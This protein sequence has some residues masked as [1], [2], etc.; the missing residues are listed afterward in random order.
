LNTLLN[1]LLSRDL[2]GVPLSPAHAETLL[3]ARG[4]DLAA[5]I[6]VAHAMRLERCGRTVR[7]CGILN[8]R[9]GGCTEDCA[10][11]AQARDSEAAVEAYALLEADPIVA[12]ARRGRAAG[13]CRFSIVTSGR[14]MTRGRDLDR[15]C[16]AIR[17]IRDEVGVAVCASLGVLDRAA[18]ER[19][20]EAGL[21]RYHHNLEAPPSLYGEICTTHPI[22]E[23]IT[24]ARDAR[25]VGLELCCGGILGLGESPSQRIELL[26]AIAEL[27][28]DAVPINF[29]EPIPGTGLA[30][31]PTLSPQEALAAVAVASLLVPEAELILCGG[32]EV[33]LRSLQPLA[34]L[35]GANGLMIGDYLTTPG[36]PPERDIEMIRDLGLEALELER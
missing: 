2:A 28:P 35:A 12:A 10:F 5:L 6:A 26:L 25:A 27:E 18:L 1:S 17:R 13:A 11:C 14:G 32:R 4:P 15:V 16:E 23:R 8:A 21:T 22:E 29:L 9:S 33:T 30:D 36:Q 3:A 20:R 7:L 19:L 24:T 34:L 31:R